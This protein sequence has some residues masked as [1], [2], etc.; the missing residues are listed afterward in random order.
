MM[1]HDVYGVFVLGFSDEV[2]YSER[3]LLLV[4]MV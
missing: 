2:F 3:L 4:L 1:R